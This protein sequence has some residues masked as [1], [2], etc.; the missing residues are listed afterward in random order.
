MPTQ[1]DDERKISLFPKPLSSDHILDAITHSP[2]GGVTLFFSKLGI[3]DI[4]P[5]E[6]EELAIAGQREYQDGGSIVERLA[7]GNNRVTALP[8]EFELFTRLRYLNLKH[9]LFS[10]FPDVLALLPSLDILDISHNKIRSL[11]SRPGN[12]IRLRVFCL[13]RNKITRLPAYLAQFQKLEMLQVDRNPIEWPPRAA[14]ES[15]GDLQDVNNAKDWIRNLQTWLE[16]DG[17]KDKEYD[18][19]GYSEQPDW[20]PERSYDSW[21]FS[22]RQGIFDAGLTPH[23]RSFSIDSNTSISSMPDSPLLTDLGD[24]KFSDNQTTSGVPDSSRNGRSVLRPSEIS[25]NGSSDTFYVSSPTLSKALYEGQAEAEQM[26]IRTTSH[27]SILRK[28]Q[29]ILMAGKKSLPDL[30]A[31]QKDSGKKIPPLPDVLNSG[32]LSDEPTTLPPTSLRQDSGSSSGSVSYPTL[33]YPEESQISE[34]RALPFVAVERSSYFQRS[35]TMV[36]T[37]SLPKSL[38]CLLE[39]ARSIL[40]SMGQLHQTLEHSMHHGGFIRSSP[41]FKK[42]L[43]PANVNM[44][45]LIRSLD[46]FDDVSRK[47][48][49]SPAVCRGLVECCRDTVTAFRKAVGLLITQIGL[50]P[51]DDPRFTRWLI[52]EL[53]GVIAEISVA[54]QAMIPEIEYL[55]PFLYSS[56][57]SQSSTFSVSGSNEAQAQDLGPAVRLRLGD[58]GTVVAGRAGRA[59][60]HAGSFSSKDVEI[61]KEL[62]SYDIVPSMTGG[63]ATHTHTPMLRTPKRQVTVPII[64]THG[65]SSLSYDPSSYFPP[66]AELHHFRQTSRISLHDP[67]SIMSPV[68]SLE[69]PASNRAFVSREV[70]QAVQSS[71]EIA[72]TVWDQIERALSD[73]VITKA[74]LRENI[75]KARSATRNLARNIADLSEEDSEIDRRLLRENAHAFLK[76]IVQ[77]SNI[78]KTHSNPRS[79]PATLRSNMV[80]LANST[81]DLVILLQV[82]SISP[83]TPRSSSPT[84]YLKYAAYNSS[85]YPMEDNQLSSS[86]S[87]TRSAQA[88]SNTAKKSLSSPYD[89]LQPVS[90]LSIKA[91]SVRRL[92]AAQ[93]ASFDVAEPG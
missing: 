49:P 32:K 89:G 8:S 38:I 46:R 90:Q 4:A 50:E 15:F 76:T 9:N 17:S 70:L 92:R 69:Y 57:F 2:D 35:S 80:K 52:L 88:T 64:P 37:E 39:I 31:V 36:I 7:L 56:V 74:D 24:Q 84:S 83:S 40:F 18:D 87:R 3:T 79:I 6:A 93:E 20:E 85:S 25:S 45:H 77:L 43:D 5:H 86:L 55:R 71:V 62:P 44:L 48:A 73:V 10:T 54:W 82:P 42:V 33:T 67:S 30:R 68:T 12:L 59:R 13:S 78:L 60:R 34:V 51:S 16:V 66:N 72:P 29:P 22:V 21:Q 28:P 91:S 58:S 53:Y 65:T 19:S 26:H 41:K 61:G 47:S 14:I 81:Q 11:P 75:E 1:N 63:L 23:A 27:A